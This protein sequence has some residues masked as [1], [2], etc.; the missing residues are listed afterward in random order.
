MMM[1]M[2]MIRPIVEFTAR[3][4][5]LIHVDSSIIVDD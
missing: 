3:L 1:M 4:E 2:M 5:H